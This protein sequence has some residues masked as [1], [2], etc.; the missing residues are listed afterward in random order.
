MPG[1]A[2]VI[3]TVVVVVQQEEEFTSLIYLYS[4]LRTKVYELAQIV[5][6]NNP[7]FY[8]FSSTCKQTERHTWFAV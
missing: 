7:P 2:A 8:L 5:Y 6:K 1:S 3:Q 4:I